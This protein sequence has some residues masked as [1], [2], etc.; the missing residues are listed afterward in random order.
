M[1]VENI[2]IMAGDKCLASAVRLHVDQGTTAK[3]WTARVNREEIGE[4]SATE[5]AVMVH[6]LL[7]VLSARVDLASLSER[8]RTLLMAYQRPDCEPVQ[9][10]DGTKVFPVQGSAASDRS[11]SPIAS[12]DGTS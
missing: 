1:S 11:S 5:S 6:M 2:T 8:D 4:L 9:A 7:N 3:I 10:L 12:S